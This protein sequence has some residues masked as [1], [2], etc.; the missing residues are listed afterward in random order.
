MLNSRYIEI[1]SSNR[2]R[3]RYPNPSQFVVE[4]SLSGSKNTSGSARDPVYNSVVK[5][6]PPNLE[7]PNVY[8]NRGYMYAST[9]NGVSTSE[10]IVGILPTYRNVANDLLPL[11]PLGNFFDRVFENGFENGYIG[12]NLELITQT[13]G[14][15]ATTLN[16]YRPIIDYRAIPSAEQFSF[17]TT[18]VDAVQPIYTTSVPL[19]SSF[20]S[21]IDNFFLG[22]TIEFTSTTDADLS[23]VQRTVKY[24]RAYDRRVFFNIPVLNATITAGDGVV[25]KVPIFEIRLSTPFSIGTLPSLLGSSTQSANITYRIRS[26]SDIPM[27]E[28]SLVSG[29]TTTFVLPASAGALNYAGSVIWISSNPTVFSGALAGASFVSS[30]GTQIEGTFTLG[31][32][33]SIYPDDFLNNMTINLTSGTFSG[34]SY[35]ITN[36]VNSTLTGTVTPGWTSLVAG[37]TSPS[38]ADTFTIVQS[39]PSHYRRISSYVT[40]TRTGT[41]IQP[42]SYTNMKGTTTAYAVGS[43]DT[44]EIL[45]FKN[46]NYNPL[47]CAESPVSQQNAHCYEIQ[48][49]SV[50]LPNVAM[51]S[52]LG[53]HIAFYPYVYIE[54]SS[55]MQGT[56]AYDFNSNN[57]AASKN[58]MFRAPMLYNYQ[59]TD[60]AFIT[61]DGHDM[62]QTLKFQPNDAFKFSVYLPNGELFLTDQD[63]FSPSEPNPLLQISACFGFKRLGNECGRRQK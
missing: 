58:V 55:V 31:A 1:T 7:F 35:I 25:L 61:M 13:T 32:G 37:T 6:P 51:K 27:N 62:I 41:V 46:D 21:N 5:Y 47:D 42:F 54:F 26:G 2:D 28:G 11:P 36:W 9:I 19:V 57:P 4:L 49:I 15:V 17:I 52:G 60:S 20:V 23:G 50:S 48:L 45:Q 10:Y 43:S 22:W 14:G 8:S 59:P 33:A 34:Y 24:Y 3:T 16:E 38:A 29:T 12:D 63:Y 39:N 56:S 53:G 44:Y 40:S 30:G 18:T